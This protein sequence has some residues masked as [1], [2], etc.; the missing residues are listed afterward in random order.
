MIAIF[1]LKFV[2]SDV[3]TVYKR[4]KDI[5]RVDKFA[6]HFYDRHADIEFRAEVLL[7]LLT[8]RKM[9]SQYKFTELN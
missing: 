8:Y 6:M 7:F 5:A 1:V 9:W 2:Q 4:S 3:G